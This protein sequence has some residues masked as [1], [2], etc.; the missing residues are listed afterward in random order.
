MGVM[1]FDL[2]DLPSRDNM[3][4]RDAIDG[5][6][7]D[8]DLEK[9]QVLVTFPHDTVDTFKTTFDKDAFKESFAKR[10]PLMCWQHD[11]RDPIGH[12]LTA[13]VMPRSNEIVGQF[14]DFDA[15]PN[16]K[17]AFS[18]IDDGTITDFSFGFRQPKYEPH[19][20]HRGVR[21]IRSAL[22]MEFSPVSVGS[23]PGAV[24][25]GL[26]EEEFMS[27]HSAAEIAAL[28]TAGVIEADE[29]KRMLAEL[30]GWR[31]HITIISPEMKRI[32]ELEAQL[33]GVRNPAAD[34]ESNAPTI[35]SLQAE[36]A[37]L[38]EALAQ[39]GTR[40]IIP[41]PDSINADAVLAA[42]PE[43]W[44]IALDGAAIAIGPA[45]TEFFREDPDEVNESAG[46]IAEAIEAALTSAGD[47]IK[48]VDTR[49]LPEE[50]Q[51]ALL[52]V[53][54]AQTSSTAMLDVLGLEGRAT[55]SKSFEPASDKG[56]ENMAPTEV[57]CELC[58]GNGETEDG[59]TCPQCGGSGVEAVTRSKDGV[60]DGV[61]NSAPKG[62]TKCAEC[63]GTGK[64]MKTDGK[65]G[66]KCPACKG[67]GWQTP[68][69]AD[70]VMNRAN[71]DG[72]STKPWS[73]FKQA[74]YTPEQWKRACLIVRGD[75]STKDMCS[76]PV[77]EPYGTYNVNGIEAAAARINQVRGDGDGDNDVAD[78]ADSLAHLYRQM[79]KDVPPEVAKLTQREDNRAEEVDAEALR[80]ELLV[81]LDKRVLP[82]V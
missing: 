44:Q 42:L 1:G 68:E 36:N 24:A 59:K 80:Q 14:S 30:D 82:K 13:Q 31:D 79:G 37:A 40:S 73:E 52:L 47:W 15:V 74:D 18:Q 49:S 65:T 78:A 23:I 26:R 81:K 71:P 38:E 46:M 6:I 2:H 28:V 66:G 8:A 7:K 57:K 72:W 56:S 69:D 41:V 62:S 29:G 27:E 50:V 21:N 33:A 58:D 35:E 75:G 25:T 76:L 32:N 17:R 12:A 11:L 9:R 5:E 43:E 3:Y 61:P 77:R 51:Q 19:P 22:M 10:M 20:R 67:K 45:G 70:D 53:D 60:A 48:D 55:K 16:S 54:A 4:L 64:V 63:K 34:A 39:V